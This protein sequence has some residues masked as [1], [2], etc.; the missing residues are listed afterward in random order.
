MQAARHSEL[1]LKAETAERAEALGFALGGLL[2]AGD[3]V[4]L[5]GEMGAG[6]TVF[7]RG[8]GAGWGATTPLSSPTYNLAH[9]HE[10]TADATKL[11]H[12]DFYRIGGA[13]EAETIGI[14]EMLDSGDI[15][16]MEWPE[17]ALDILPCERLW[18]DIIRRENEARDLYFHGRGERY[19]ALLDELRR[20]LRLR[21]ERSHAAGD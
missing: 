10:R 2:Q 16:I 19:F 3:I 5:S 18:I 7:S 14:H 8:I 15:L 11:Y 13:G 6:K 4:C 17:R 9:E 1:Q 12:L 21:R 20:S